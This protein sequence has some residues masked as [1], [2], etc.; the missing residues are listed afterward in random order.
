MF[1]SFS[2]QLQ[3][4]NFKSSGFLVHPIKSPAILINYRRVIDQEDFEESTLIKTDLEDVTE[5][6]PDATVTSVKVE[7]GKIKNDS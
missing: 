2:G 3:G 5:D 6:V 1:L 4:K 7:V